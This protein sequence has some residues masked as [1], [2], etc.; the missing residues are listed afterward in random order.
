MYCVNVISLFLQV[1]LLQL[2]AVSDCVADNGN[3]YSQ[4]NIK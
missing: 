2:M 3:I 1:Y 4:I